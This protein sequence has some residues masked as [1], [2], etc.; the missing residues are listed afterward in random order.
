MSNGKRRSLTALSIMKQ[1]RVQLATLVVVLTLIV[2]AL[3]NA[4]TRSVQAES[5][6]NAADEHIITLHDNGTEKGF[7]TKATTLRDALAQAGV[8][9][10]P[11]DR[12]E[13]AL[14]ETLVAASYEVNI[15]RARLVVVRDQGSETK[16]ITAFRTGK[17]IA[18][19]LQLGLHSE[20]HAV[21]TPSTNM[22]ADGGAEVLTITRANPVTFVFYG[23]TIQAYT[24]AKTVGEMLM[25]KSIT[26]AANDTLSPA[27]ST[28]ITSG[29]KVELWK[30]GEQTATV[31]EEVAFAVEQIRDA[32]RERGYKEVKTAGVPG[33][34][35]VT[36]KIVMQ[37]G[38]EV[39][40]QVVNSV[41]IKEPV[42][43]VEVI[44]AKG[45]FTTPGENEIIT[46]NF[47]IAQGFSREQTA[48]IMGNLMQEHKF[49]TS[50]DGLAQW[51]GGRKAALMALPD[52]YNIYTQ[53]EFM[54]SELNGRY[55]GAK[56]AVLAAT[57][58]E[59]AMY[60]FQDR[61]EGC[62]MCRSDLRLTYAYNILA[63]H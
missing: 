27:A 50:G 28:P 32:N 44:G 55:S 26:P 6:M 17:Q 5:A 18:E 30:N 8:R 45:S 41:T 60:A 29:M 37:N 31:D 4:L 57:T 12:T 3:S 19:Q 22:L 10:D 48:G 38:L 61:Y 53:L 62:G 20:D 54:M 1:T 21:L 25:Q 15:Y 56:N 63:S 24:H 39:S 16:V 2:V 59:A 35:A 9:L 52:P 43:Q 14:D 42:K 23:K 51:T 11:H 33:K 7:I 46:W 13:P 36:Y 34:K 47:L 49:N 40:R 58:V